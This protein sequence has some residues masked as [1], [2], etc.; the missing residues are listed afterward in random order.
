MIELVERQLLA[1]TANAVLALYGDPQPSDSTEVEA[2]TARLNELAEAMRRL[3]GEVMLAVDR[4]AD[5][6]PE[7]EPSEQEKQGG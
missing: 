6:S 1:A 7:Q 2:V 3:G 5:E 4:Q